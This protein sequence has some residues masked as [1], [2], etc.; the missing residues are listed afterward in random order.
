VKLQ[1]CGGIG[2]ALDTLA[3]ARAHGMKAQ[4][5]CMIES[6]LGIAAAAQIAPLFDWVDLDGNLLIQDDPFLG[7]PVKDGRIVLRDA[8]GVGAEP[9]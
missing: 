6:S 1:K 4:L 8:P 9:V 3:A 5:G 7:H 2:E